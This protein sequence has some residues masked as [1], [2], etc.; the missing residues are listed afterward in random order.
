MARMAS[1]IIVELA[2]RWFAIPFECPCCG[3][4]PDGELTAAPRAGASRGADT[5]S[6]AGIEF[7][8]C[9]RCLAH[10]AAWADATAT[11]SGVALI[12]I[13][14]GLVVALA[15]R[16]AIGATIAVSSIPLAMAA[17][18]LARARARAACGP[19]C[20]SPGHAVTY[21][22]S[23]GGI[24]AFSFESP[25]YTARFAEQ[26]ASALT[27]AG[28][29]LRALIEGHRVARLAVPTPAAPATVVGPPP[30]IADWLAKLEAQTS[31]VARR[32]TLSRALEVA[33][34]AGDRRRLVVAACRLELAPL[35]DKIDERSSAAVRR[36][37]LEAAIAQVR[38]DNLDDE[39]RD[40]LL[41]ELET[42]LR[43]VT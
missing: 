23:A 15:G 17:G 2:A 9:L 43:A 26:N 42:R 38:A 24:R 13:S 11:A 1:A 31:R 4:A 18:A 25:T 7:P 22:G 6:E 40:A 19:A 41:H 37:Q 10:A 16:I 32:N 20:A 8:Y 21:L 33:H 28:P 29:Q 36:H 12:A 14:T 30:T 39:L 5:S 34:D 3:A 35:V 27:N